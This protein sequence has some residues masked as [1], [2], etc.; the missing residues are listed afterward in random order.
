MDPNKKNI[1]YKGLAITFSIMFFSLLFNQ[2]IY[3]KKIS[4]LDQGIAHLRDEINEEKLFIA[5]FDEFSK[6]FNVCK[7]I[8]SY[9]SGLSDKVFETGLNIEKTYKDEESIEEFKQIQK[10]WVYLNIELWLRL[11]KYNKTCF[12]KRNYILYFYPYQC[13]EC[14]PYSTELNRLNKKYGN[15]LWLISIPGKIEIKMVKMVMKYFGI[16]TLPAVVVNGRLLK[17][18]N[19]VGQIEKAITAGYKKR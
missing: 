7:I 13:H 15:D 18:N 9:L 12:N 14:A 1:I 10:D 2:F 3:Q 19:I 8:D 11:L 4:R 5:F 17:G 16:K 6:D